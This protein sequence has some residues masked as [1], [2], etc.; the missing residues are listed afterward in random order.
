MLFNKFGNLDSS[1]GG[2]DDRLY[3]L[4]YNAMKYSSDHEAFAKQLSEDLDLLIST[5]RR[6]IK[7]LK[8]RVVLS[9]QPDMIAVIAS[10]LK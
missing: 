9:E 5:K 7:T 4:K 1:S 3:V 8:K 10:K 6:P 2:I